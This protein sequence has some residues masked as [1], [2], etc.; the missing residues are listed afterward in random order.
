MEHPIHLVFGFDPANHV[1]HAATLAGAPGQ[2]CR[3]HVQHK[4]TLVEALSHACY[5]QVLRMVAPIEVTSH[6][7]C[8]RI[9]GGAT[10]M[11]AEA[12]WDVYVLRYLL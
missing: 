7:C 11:V 6:S 12:V 2:A 3:R 10:V 9:E 5:R 1:L 4:A 8:Y